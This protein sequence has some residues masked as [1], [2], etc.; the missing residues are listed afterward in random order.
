MT[1]SGGMHEVELCRVSL[2]F[3]HRFKRFEAPIKVVGRQLAIIRPHSQY[4]RLILQKHLGRVCNR[5]GC[6]AAWIE[7]FVA[8]GHVASGHIVSS[9]LRSY[10]PGPL[11]R[12][13]LHVELGFQNRRLKDSARKLRY[14]GSRSRTSSPW[15]WND[16][17]QF[18]FDGSGHVPMAW[19]ARSPPSPSPQPKRRDRAYCSTWMR[20]GTGVGSFSLRRL[21]L[22]RWFV[23]ANSANLIAD[24][25]AADVYGRFATAWREVG[26]PD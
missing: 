1:R 11:R 19:S 8:S 15:F 18:C 14:L 22:F 21:L 10:A 26:L 6:D 17:Q 9:L 2:L 23:I 3:C 16:C 4:R 25:L 5:H 24:A 12:Q 20:S 13:C 7:A